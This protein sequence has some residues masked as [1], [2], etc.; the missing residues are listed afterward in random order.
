MA[1]S[2]SSAVKDFLQLDEY[3]GIFTMFIIYIILCHTS[4]LILLVKL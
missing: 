4:K 3:L 1:P 2:S